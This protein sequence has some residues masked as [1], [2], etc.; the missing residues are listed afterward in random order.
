MSTHRG[1]ARS[2]G[3]IGSL[4]AVS[5][6]LGF[7]RDMVIAAAFG[8]GYAAEAFVVSFKIPNLLRDLV[9][10]GAAN[11]A[12]V[13]VLT[14]Y[15][16]KRPAEY[17]GLVSTLLGVSAGVLLVLT[18]AGVLL[19]P[20]L[21]S[22]IAPGFTSSAEP[23]KYPLA[24]ELTRWMFPYVFLIGLSAWAMGTLHSL[25]RFTAS[26]L[27]PILLNVCMI[28]AGFA[29]EP[30]YGPYALVGGVLIGGALQL[31]CQ[32]PALWKAGFRYTPPGRSL[33]AAARVGKL[34]VPRA[35]GSA[36][37]QV[38][39]FV[40]SILASFE[41]WV[42]LGG[43]SA[44]Y[45]SNRL[46]QLPLA[47]FGLSLAQ[48]LLPTF[49]AQIV[50]GRPDEMK[51]TLVFA[52]RLVAML[53]VPAAAGLIV[54]AGP[55]VRT[56]FER[57]E[58]DAYSTDITSRALFCYGWGLVSCCVVKILV[59]AFYAMQDTRTPVRTMALCVAL[60]VPLSLLLMRPL[61]IGGLTL[62]SSLSATLNAVLL[63]GALARRIGPL[64]TA[65][66]RDAALKTL[67]CGA[68]MAVTVLLAD[69]HVLTPLEEAS[70]TV[71]ATAL[72]AVIVAGGAVYFGA[73]AAAGYPELSR[74]R[75]WRG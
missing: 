57:G 36:I 27:G 10:E 73:L 43:Q 6:V 4:T 72:A 52:L 9:G 17:W 14:E 29:L 59:N 64:D 23:E 35:L 25:G 65:A 41:H 33:E 22:L 60:H 55:I 53:V 8:T 71:R 40:D 1:V 39:V 51:K 13:P 42:G 63:Y 24:V 38:N 12:L 68:L 56:I 62:S 7:V 16:Q 19:A 74:L 2:A 48:A 34:L 30:T 67:G 75:R 58:F 28:I 21:V 37:Y 70:V 47:L 11:A 18:A 5:R 20:Q 54:L 66:L 49:S 45:Y 46:F 26:A 69:R 31:I 44:L 32:L 61:G 15:R 3:V 50:Q